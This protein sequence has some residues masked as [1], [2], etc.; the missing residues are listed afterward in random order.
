VLSL[1]SFRTFRSGDLPDITARCFWAALLAYS[2]IN[3][4][5]YPAILQYQAGTEA[6]NYVSKPGGARPAGTDAT[7]V[8]VPADAA[9]GPIVYMLEETPANYSF[10]FY[11]RL[12]VERIGVNHLP[13][14]LKAGP[15]VAFLPTA[16]TD[17]LVRKGFQVTEIKKF[18]NFHISQ[19]TGEF[20]NYKTR[21]STLEWYSL[22]SVH[23]DM[24]VRGGLPVS[25]GVLAP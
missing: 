25:P 20:L 10:E 13:L 12:P 22:V 19:L 17:S 3:F 4:C 8:P 11:C 7:V 18:P 14:V 23:A 5:L 2:F 9:T 15:A 6:G 1:L 16:Y 21:A 24:P